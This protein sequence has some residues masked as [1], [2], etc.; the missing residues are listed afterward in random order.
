MGRLMVLFVFFLPAVGNAEEAPKPVWLVVAREAFT[1]AVEPLAAHRAGDGLETVVSTEGVAEALAGLTRPPAY[2]LLVGD[3][4]KGREAERW[5]LP[6]AQRPLYRWMLTQ[7]MTFASDSHFGDLDRD[8]VQD[9]PVG[10]IPARNADEVSTVV[11][12]IIAFENRKATTADL[13]LNLWG[14]TPNYGPAFD[15][16]QTSFLLNSLRRDAPPWLDLWIISSD[17]NHPLCGWP[18]DQ[19]D[20]FSRRMAEG[21][22]I[23]ALMGHANADFFLSIN[24]DGKELGYTADSAREILSQ[25]APSA[26]LLFFSCD[27]GNFARE[28]PC[29]AESFLFFHAGPV[30]TVA[31]STNSHPLTNYFTA[32]SMAAELGG[33]T[34]RYGDLWLDSQKKARNREVNF[35]TVVA[36]ELKE[37]EGK[38]EEEIDV[39][40]LKGDQLLMYA[41]LGDPATRIRL[42]ETLRGSV[43]KR[44]DGWFWRV[45]KPM[46]ATALEVAFRLGK[47]PLLRQFG[48]SANRDEAMSR[49][50]DANG[51]L[52]YSLLDPPAN[53]APWEGVV[54]KKGLLRLTATGPGVCATVVFELH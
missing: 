3:Y 5:Y 17:R 47:P 9:I 54:T 28:T 31:A 40:K 44:D 11:Q 22:L 14:G 50:G 8:G 1:G 37:I 15:A 43:E 19:P 34:A 6:T 18:A 10:R 41:F 12:K 51:Q 38:L 29:M 23:N 25:G 53:D 24:V 42:P 46:G 7:R 36:N 20:L 39:D 4:E 2:L 26:P 13:R 16:V 48:R 33:R 35:F 27:S 21:A 45:D 32:T 30:A 52:G 49:F